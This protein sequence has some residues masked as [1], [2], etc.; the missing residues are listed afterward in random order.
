MF[1]I[2]YY[3]CLKLAN[4][5]VANQMVANRLVSVKCF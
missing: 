5:T 1:N 2:Q 3:T 4:R